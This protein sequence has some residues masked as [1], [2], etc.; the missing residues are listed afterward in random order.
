MTL[1]LGDNDTAGQIG[2]A[3]AASA[4]NEGATLRIVVSRTGVNLARDVTVD[5]GLALTGT[6]PTAQQGVDFTGGTGT[7]TFGPGATSAVIEIGA[8]QDGVIGPA[9][10]FTL[11]LSNPSS[12]STL[13]ARTFHVVTIRD[14]TQA[15]VIQ[16]MPAAVTANENGGAVTLTIQ[17]TGTNLAQD[18]NVSYALDPINR[19][20]ATP[21]VD[22]TFAAGTVT[23]G[24]GETT[25]T[26]TLTPLSDALPEPT[27]TI[28]ITLHS[29]TGGATLGANKTMVVNLVNQP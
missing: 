22:Y 12:G 11:Q 29:P 27:E 25:K 5:Y 1:V 20:T 2:F 9:K 15:G 6:P 24:A 23:F 3:A 8:L 4:V 10:T 21:D 14:T 19:G 16:W 17:R 7:L 26:V 28:R 13:S 18:I